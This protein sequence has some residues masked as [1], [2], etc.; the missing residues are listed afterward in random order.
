MSQY[1]MIEKYIND[2]GSISPMEAFMDLGITKLATRIS[3]M[4]RNGY[5]FEQ[6]PETRK[7]RFGKECRYMRYMKAVQP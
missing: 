6:K 3:E 7:N 5:K 4:R 2:N 1:E